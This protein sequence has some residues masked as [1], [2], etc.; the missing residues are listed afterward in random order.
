MPPVRR[1]WSRRLV[2]GF[3]IL[4]V[5][6]PALVEQVNANNSI[7][8]Q[9]NSDP[10]QVSGIAQRVVVGNPLVVTAVTVQFQNTSPKSGYAYIDLVNYNGTGNPSNQSAGILGTST[11]LYPGVNGG[12]F[13]FNMPA[14]AVPAGTFYVVGRT[15]YVSVNADSACLIV[16]GGTAQPATM[17]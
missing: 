1:A 12:S 2:S 5:T 13:T 14:V 9:E 11:N 10:L 3:T 7:L 16:T 15:Q 6:N 17:V 8:V 4:T